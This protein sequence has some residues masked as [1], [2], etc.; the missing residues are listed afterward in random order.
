MNDICNDDIICN[1]LYLK[2]LT[3]AISC[4]DHYDLYLII[5]KC[6]PYVGHVLG[7]ILSLTC[8]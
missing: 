7:F 8:Y 1:A 5:Y 2:C 3:N 4:Y 6:L